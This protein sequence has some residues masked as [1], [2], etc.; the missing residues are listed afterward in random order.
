[1]AIIFSYDKLT[2]SLC[3]FCTILSHHGITLYIS[4]KKYKT[5][6]NDIFRL[7]QSTGSL[8]PCFQVTLDFLELKG[9]THHL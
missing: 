4:S 1:M 2:T 5:I 8:M 7:K 3:L 6:Q 9:N